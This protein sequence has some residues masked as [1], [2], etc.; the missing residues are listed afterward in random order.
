MLI[1]NVL[2]ALLATLLAIPVIWFFIQIAAACYTRGGP[3]PNETPCPA[4]ADSLRIA[5]LIPAHNESMN[6]VPTLR[7]VQQQGLANLRVVVVADNCNDDT[8]AVARQEGAEVVERTNPLHRGK[9]YALD[10][11]V[12]H[13]QHNP[14]DVVVILDAD[15]LLE[16]DVLQSLGM[17]ALTTMRPAQALYLMKNPD[18]G[19]SIRSKIAEF[20]WLVKNH[21]R[22][23]GLH[24]LGLPCQLT[25]SGMAFPWPVLNAVPLATGEIVEDMKLGIA[26][27]SLGHPPSFSEHTVVSSMFPTNLEGVKSQRTRWEHG[28]LA[29]IFKEGFPK[30][31][32]AL[33]TRNMPLFFLALD[34]CIPPLALLIALTLAWQFLAGIYW[35]WSG[36]YLPL[37]AGAIYLLGTGL[38][39]A[40]AW[41]KFGRH[42][43][44]GRELLMA[45][46][47][48]ISKLSVYVGFV[49]RRQAEWVRSKRD[50]E[51][52]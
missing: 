2:M 22:P 32:I 42:I 14:P 7:S 35:I 20:A 11:G 17:L 45:P 1:L 31:Q 48:I 33:A 50:N 21:V 27:T 36:N 12:K 3:R 15:C 4:A 43:I 52:K 46:G 30:L 13:L 49:F 38:A 28:H 9:G 47:Y 19:A 18:G 39:V 25:G 5:V 26:L 8:A 44:S 34:L 41:R 16:H 24:T 6:L 37:V 23:R 51:S 29:M 40:L 10:F